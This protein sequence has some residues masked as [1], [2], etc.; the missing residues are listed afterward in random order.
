MKLASS[1]IDGEYQPRAGLDANLGKAAGGGANIEHHLAIRR[2]RPLSEGEG[3][4]QG[5]A[6]PAVRR[7]GGDLGCRI[8]QFR[9]L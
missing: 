2:H 5:R 3:E 7:P 1:Y 6:D 4:L 8:H 9:R